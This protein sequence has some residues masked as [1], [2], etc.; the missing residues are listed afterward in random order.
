MT[1]M[2]LF[3]SVAAVLALL[4]VIACS[5]NS[6]R[7]F[8]V[9]QA[10]GGIPVVC[11]LLLMKGVE[12]ILRGDV[13]AQEPVW[14]EAADGR[15]LSVVWPDGFSVG[16]EPGAVLYDEK[17]LRVASAGEQVALTQ[18]AWESAAGTFDDP[19]YATGFVF[20]GCYLRAT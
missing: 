20:T 18:V 3:R 10:E 11:S 5:T 12:G 2:G 6:L 4:S 1:R 13:F 8:R 15:H 14:L 17:Q 7:T 19:Y 9:I 16:F